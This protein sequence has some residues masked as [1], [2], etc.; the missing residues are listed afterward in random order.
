ML[1]PR[2]TDDPHTP[3]AVVYAST[4]SV[5]WLQHSY[6]IPRLYQISDSSGFS[7]KHRQ[8]HPPRCQK[9]ISHMQDSQP[10]CP[11]H[12]CTDLQRPG[13]RVQRVVVLRVVVVEHADRAPVGRI[14]VVDVDSLF[15][16]W[17]IKYQAACQSP[18]AHATAN[19]EVET[20][21]SGQGKFNA[22]PCALWCTPSASYSNGPTSTKP[23]RRRGSRRWSAADRSLQ[24]LGCPSRCR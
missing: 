21:G 13:V 22:P 10:P 14:A 18:P 11:H 20:G 4:A 23:D 24:S 19:N 3:A 12:R 6:R 1:P 16:L 17:S 5:I 8:H 7:C 9:S 2:R 15:I